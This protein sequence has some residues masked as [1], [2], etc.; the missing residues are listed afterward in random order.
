MKLDARRI[1]A[2]LKDPGTCRVVLLHG[3]D[4]GLIRDRA[5][6]YLGEDRSYYISDSRDYFNP[7]LDSVRGRAPLFPSGSVRHETLHGR[8]LRIVRAVPTTPAIPPPRRSSPSR[9]TTPGS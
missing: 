6:V 5:D 2:F 3:E 4:A 9:A 8:S 7:L 1:P